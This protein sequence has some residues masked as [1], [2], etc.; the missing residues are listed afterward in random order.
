MKISIN[1]P[2]YIPWLGYF[3]RIA[4]SDVH[5][6]LDHVQFEK[7]SMVNRNII[8]TKNGPLMLTIP[9]ET[10]GKFGDISINT[11]K[12][13][14]NKSWMKKHWNSIFFNYKNAKYFNDYAT[15]L[16]KFYTLE[17]NL[18]LNNFL[19]NQL[20]F[21]LRALEIKTPILYSSEMNIKEK[22]S[23]L[24][25]EICKKTKAT[26]YI[27]GPFGRDYLNVGDF[28]QS[29]INIEFQ[30]YIHPQYKQFTELFISNL[31]ILDLLFHHGKDSLDILR[32]KK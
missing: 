20:S 24:I 23:D 8:A 31:S 9:I 26:H 15:E 11:V 4:N 19:K 12:I 32:N 5:I 7:N 6:V 30:N 28:Y 13:S 29:N 22:K 3:E 18:L 16:E 10:S 27:S 21:L 1:Q 2:A 25:L 14:S 17:N